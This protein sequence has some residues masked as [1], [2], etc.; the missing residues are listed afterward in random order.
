M[1]AQREVDV[2]FPLQD[3][4]SICSRGSL[5]FHQVMQHIGTRASQDICIKLPLNSRTTEQK[6][7]QKQTNNNN[8]KKHKEL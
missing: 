3:D 1:E 7:K 6:K 8:D 2:N 5:Y 4:P